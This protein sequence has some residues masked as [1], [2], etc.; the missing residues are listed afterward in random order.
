MTGY[1]IKD[2]LVEITYQLEHMYLD[3]Q[4]GVEEDTHQGSLTSR[5]LHLQGKRT[6]QSGLPS[7]KPWLIGMDGTMKTGSITFFPELKGKRVNLFF[8]Q[9]P[10]DMLNNYSALMSEMARRYRV[11]ETS[12]SFAAKFS[13]RSQRHGEKVDD[14]AAGLKGF[15]IK[16]MNTETEGHVMKIW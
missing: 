8:S 13:K 12:R 5:Y 2:N 16:G 10:P 1:G 9:L 15:T 14:Y 4:E 6:G 7:L 3:M 11:I